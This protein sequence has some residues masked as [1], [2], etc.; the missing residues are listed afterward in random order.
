MKTGQAKPFI[1]VLLLLV[2]ILSCSNAKG[3][4]RL[5]KLSGSPEGASTGTLESENPSRP[6]VMAGNNAKMVSTEPGEEAVKR[7]FPGGMDI[8]WKA[9]SEGLYYF[10]AL[11]SRFPR[12]FFELEQSGFF[13]IR[14]IDQVTGRPILYLDGPASS[15]DPANLYISASVNRWDASGFGPSETDSSCVLS[16]WTTD[17]GKKWEFEGAKQLRESYHNQTALRGAMLCSFFNGCLEEYAFGHNKMPDDSDEL[18]D[19]AWGVVQKWALNNPA[20]DISRPNTFL[21]GID[22]SQ[23]I[24]CA[25]W[26]DNNARKFR[27]VF[28]YSPWPSQGWAKL[29]SEQEMVNLAN[30]LFID[31]GL[32]ITD[33]LPNDYVPPLVLWR[34]SLLVDH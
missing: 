11:N 25:E 23:Q 16:T 29:P 12:S 10:L 28:N 6:D 22:K 17:E 33:M 20:L 3:I 32:G 2:C 18:F 26:R 7:L 24:A 34:C 9:L 5:H 19:R 4:P 1:I 14:P 30:K 27:R 13:P 8:R 31:N 21:F 15:G